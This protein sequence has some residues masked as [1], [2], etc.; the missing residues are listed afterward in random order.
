MGSEM[1][2]RVSCGPLRCMPGGIVAES[3]A[4]RPTSLQQTPHLLRTG[5]PAVAAAM[6]TA[7]TVLYTH[8]PLPTN[9]AV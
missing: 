5:L 6:A 2:I 9:R 3:V 7:V 1:C 8:L 4:V